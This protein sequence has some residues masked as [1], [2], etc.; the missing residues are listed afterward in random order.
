[1]NK[2]RFK[3]LII[4]FLLSSLAG[5]QSN[6]STGP[7]EYNEEKFNMKIIDI[8]NKEGD[9]NTFIVLVDFDGNVR[10]SDRTYSLEEIREVKTTA[11]FVEKNNLRVGSIYK[12]VMHKKVEG[13][14]N[15]DDEIIQW[16][17]SFKE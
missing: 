5:C 14:G 4:I 12:G 1:M 2:I 10:F 15:C 13:T 8:L 9:P 7:C 6:T 11:T 16:H 3:S 17:N